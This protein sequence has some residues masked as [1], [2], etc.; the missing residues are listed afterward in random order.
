MNSNPREICGVEAHN[1]THS[2]LLRLCGSVGTAALQET[3]ERFVRPAIIHS[4][5][6]VV[7]LGEEVA[8]RKAAVANTP[9]VSLYLGDRDLV[10]AKQVPDFRRA[11]MNEFSAEFD[12]KLQLR[13]LLG[14]DSA[15]K[16]VPCLQNHDRQA[17][18]RKFRCRRQTSGAGSNYNHIGVICRRRFLL[19]TR[20]NSI[21]N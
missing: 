6:N 5:Q 17:A 20:H 7:D 12:R 15:T 16:A 9:V 1:V 19:V 10:L 18:L 4:P 2:L 13:V 14:E 8:G 11:A 21:V 3:L